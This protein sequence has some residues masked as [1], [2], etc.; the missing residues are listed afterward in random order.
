MAKLIIPIGIPGC[1]KST[2]SAR[3][4]DHVI[5][6]D[7]IREKMGDINDQS[8]NDEVFDKFHTNVR[9]YLELTLPVAS[10]VADATN[11]TRRARMKLYEIAD[12]AGAEVHIFL[13]TNNVQ[14][15]DRNLMRERTVPNDAMLRMLANYEKTLA[16]LPQE[17]SRY[18]TLTKI[19]SVI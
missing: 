8:K 18:H 6:T 11:L 13:F 17:R 9:D 3:Y 14:A 4:F 1:G 7:R 5:S 16:E 12:E 10:V 2:W 15:L 19:S